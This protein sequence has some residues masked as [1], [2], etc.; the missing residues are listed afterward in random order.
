LPLFIFI[1]VAASAHSGFL[2]ASELNKYYA[3][4]GHYPPKALF[5]GA[6]GIVFCKCDISSSGAISECTVVSGTND[7]FNNEA[8]RLLKGMPLAA[9]TERPSLETRDL[10]VHFS[11]IDGRGL[12]TDAADSID[13]KAHPPYDLQEY[14][15]NNIHLSAAGIE[16]GDTVTYISLRILKNGMPDS[17]SVV[18]SW[19]KT[20][21]L[22]IMQAM[23]KMARWVPA[24]KYGTAYDTWL[25]ICLRLR[26][27]GSQVI[28]T[29]DS[30]ANNKVYNLVEQMPHPP[31]DLV[32]YLSDNLKYPK[33][34][35]K[36]NVQGRVVVRFVVGSD[37]NIRG[38]KV[39]K[40]L[41]D[42]LDEEAL[43]VIGQMDPWIP[44]KQNGKPVAVYFTLPISFK[45]D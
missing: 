21:K 8:V 19:L 1:Q 22:P 29:I 18:N 27:S 23:T 45:L 20:S 4:K 11:I 6:Q 14:I 35:R 15:N 17:F 38:C 41:D 40:H 13:I 16:A 3:E 10:A 24:C 42:D 32:K 34:A 43:R 12:I 9:N 36:N 39:V 37:G 28:A 25:S 2:T 31:Y 26:V 30:T 44:G 5:S 33:R 7:E